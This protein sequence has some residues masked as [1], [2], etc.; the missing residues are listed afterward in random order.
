LCFLDLKRHRNIVSQE[1]C[2]GQ[3]KADRINIRTEDSLI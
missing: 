3:Y 1:I 2:S